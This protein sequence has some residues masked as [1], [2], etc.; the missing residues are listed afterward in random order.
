MQNIRFEP[1][2]L[3]PS[4]RAL[5]EEVRAFLREEL[6]PKGPT[7]R[8]FSWGTSFDREFSRKVGA[9]GWIGMTWPRKYGGGER[10]ALERWVVQEEMLAAGA[11][12]MCHWLADRQYGPM[13][14]KFGT[15]A[16]REEF[17]PGMVKGE[18][19]FS[20]GMSEPDAG[21]DLAGV[22]TKAVRVDGGWELSGTKVWT[23]GAHLA[24]YALAL[25]RTGG[26]ET[27]KH[28]G[29]SQFIV[30]L[31]GQGVTVRPIYDVIGHHHFNEVHFDHAFVPNH[32]MVGGEGDGWKQVTNELAFER[33]GPDRYL[34]S[35]RL[36]F[37]LIRAAGAKPSERS[38]VAIGRLAA[39]LS[40]LRQMS[41]SVATM[42]EAGRDPAV[43][44]S[45]VKDVGTQHEQWLP[46]VVHDLLG[47]EPRL[48]TGG[49]LA[50]SHA[51]I[52][53]N[54]PTFTI[55]GGAREVVRGIIA[56]GLGL[57]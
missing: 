9:R 48:D 32:R 20:I 6:G 2:E 37:E 28:A 33:S 35:V 12:C 50:R 7:P 53:V 23:T 4:A 18:T 24:D 56:R 49:D 21:S 55:R 8:A 52:V 13:L 51:Y 26:P 1:G 30:D 42:L 54:A 29:L 31:K 47:T 41:L 14:L 5:R 39:Q 16:Q 40:T 25:V 43:E 36:Y 45:M 27:Q 46:E 44:A 34:A 15:E 3:P 38:A 57:R 10:S 17:L 22:R 11:P 19:M